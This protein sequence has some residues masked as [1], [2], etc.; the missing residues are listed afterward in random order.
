MTRTPQLTITTPDA[1]STVVRGHPV[2]H[3]SGTSSVLDGVEQDRPTLNTPSERPS[4]KSAPDQT[5]T[6][7]DQIHWDGVPALSLGGTDYVQS[8]P[9]SATLKVS[10]PILGTAT[11]GVYVGSAG[12]EAFK[13]SSTQLGHSFGRRRKSAGVVARSQHPSTC[14][15]T[16]A[17]E[18]TSRVCR[19]TCRSTVAMD[20]SC[21]ETV[22]H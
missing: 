22:R 17:I 13:G 1:L 18:I 14:V 21:A 6:R 3:Q 2:F 20:S 11:S 9:G 8:S 4:C 12:A 15:S 16:G 5:T 10:G 19:E 7:R